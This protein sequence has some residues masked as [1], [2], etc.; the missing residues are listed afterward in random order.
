MYLIRSQ[1]M[2]NRFVCCGVVLGS[3]V[4]CSQPLSSPHSVF[5][6]VALIC[7]VVCMQ[8][9][10]E[11]ASGSVVNNYEISIQFN[12]QGT[13]SSTAFLCLLTEV[14]VST[15]ICPGALTCLFFSMLHNSISSRPVVDALLFRLD[16][17][18][19]GLGSVFPNGRGSHYSASLYS[20]GARGRA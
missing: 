14:D 19:H 2:C 15:I 12:W 8:V 6:T 17:G 3:V 16:R 13:S 7:L 10:A 18:T 20:S 1:L 5:L 9:Y 11:P 4:L